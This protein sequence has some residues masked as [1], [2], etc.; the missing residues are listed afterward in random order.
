[1]GR[2]TTYLNED[3][4]NASN[5]IFR[6]LGQQINQVGGAYIEKQKN[7]NKLTDDIKR[8]ILEGYA[9]GT[10]TPKKGATINWRQLGVPQGIDMG[11][12]QPVNRTSGTSVS[13]T[14]RPYSEI[15]KAQEIAGRTPEDYRKAGMATGGNRKLGTGILGTGLGPGSQRNPIVMSPV[16]QSQQKMAQDIIANPYKKTYRFGGG[17]PE[18]EN[19]IISDTEGNQY[20]ASEYEEG[21]TAEIDGVQYQVTNGQWTEI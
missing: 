21:T 7:K 3:P 11:Q 20:D 5:D 12:F 14:Q 8:A 19:A 18:E 10:I 1:M 4:E 17:L 6:G 2:Y 16:A 13:I 15:V 9:K